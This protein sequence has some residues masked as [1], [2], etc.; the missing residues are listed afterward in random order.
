MDLPKS[1]F[2][3]SIPTN[4][5]ACFSFRSQRKHPKEPLK[6]LLLSAQGPNGTRV[7]LGTIT[8]EKGRIE[9]LE[10]REAVDGKVQEGRGQLKNF[11]KCSVVGCVPAG[12]GCLLGGATWLPCFCLW[13]G[14]SVISCGLL[15]I[16]FPQ[17]SSAGRTS[18]AQ[19]LRQLGDVGGDAP[20][21]VA[22][23][24][25]CPR[26]FQGLPTR[27]TRTKTLSITPVPFGYNKTV[28]AALRV[29]W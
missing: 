24:R 5:T 29:M 6:H 27:R 21:L 16:F 19:K 18:A 2:V 10:E 9:V 13:C 4:S 23:S 25:F 17:R 28:L 3:L 8:D 26:V 22:G 1:R 12:L 14:G 11:F 7:F 15:E 20:R